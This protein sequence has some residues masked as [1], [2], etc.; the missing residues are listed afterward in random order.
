MQTLIVALLVIGCS[1]Y[2]VWSLMPAAARRST[3]AV[4]LRLPLPGAVAS[5][6]RE[7]TQASSGC[8]CSGCDRAEKKP[9]PAAEQPITVHRRVRE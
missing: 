1:A 2:V 6:L 8:A 5:R 4:L 9:Q 7:A 3:A